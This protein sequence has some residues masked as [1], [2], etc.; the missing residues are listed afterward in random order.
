MSDNQV[1]GHGLVP[2]DIISNLGPIELPRTLVK[3]VAVRLYT[4]TSTS[5]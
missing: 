2:F 3:I 1:F 4:A 5:K